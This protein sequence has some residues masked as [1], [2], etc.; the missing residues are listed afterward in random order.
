MIISV[1]KPVRNIAEDF[2]KVCERRR[3]RQVRTDLAALRDRV[4]AA[5]VAYDA[6]GG[7]PCKVSPLSLKKEDREALQG[8]YDH[9]YQGKVLERLRVDAFKSTP[10]RVCPM[11][12]FGQV[13]E[14]DHYLPIDKFSEFSILAFNLVPL[15]DSCNGNKSNL[16]GDASGRFFHVYYDRVARGDKLLTVKVDLVR[17]GVAVV[18]AV[19]PDLPR[20]VYLNASYQ[21]EKLKLSE[22]YVDASSRELSE[23]SSLFALHHNLFGPAGVRD[24]ASD[25]ARQFKKLYGDHHWGVALYDALCANKAFCSG[26]FQLL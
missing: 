1:K 2:D 17:R 24:F 20:A 15:C 16:V 7:S 19:N 10:N 21:F 12:G 25:Q 4:M 18:F 22:R 6:E 14:L 5:Y 8:N 26:G 13:A 11:C 9:T 23:R 3:P